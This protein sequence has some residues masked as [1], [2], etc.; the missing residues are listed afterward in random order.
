MTRLLSIRR[1]LRR[2]EAALYIGLKPT[3]FDQLVRE[4]RLPE[5]VRI[6]GCVVWDVKKLDAAFDELSDPR[7]VWDD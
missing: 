6:D 7:N 2:E 5:P 3:K 4:K 1:G